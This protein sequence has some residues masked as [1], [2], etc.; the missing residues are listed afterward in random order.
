MIFTPHTTHHTHTHTHTIG[1]SFIHFQN[2]RVDDIH[3]THHTHTHTHTHNWFFIHPLP[4]WSEFE[5]SYFSNGLFQ[6]KV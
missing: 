1:F 6:Q 5:F 3:S 2:G 4:K